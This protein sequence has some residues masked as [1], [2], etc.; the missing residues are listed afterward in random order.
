DPQSRTIRCDVRARCLRA[1]LCSA[2][3]RS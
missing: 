3:R 1:R 2:H